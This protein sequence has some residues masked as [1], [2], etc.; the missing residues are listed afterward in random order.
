MYKPKRISLICPHC[1]QTFE[2][3]KKKYTAEIKQGKLPRDFF[4]SLK[5]KNFYKGITKDLECK[6]CGK[7]HTRSKSKIESENTFCSQSCSATFNNKNKKFGTRRSKLE[8]YLEEKLR[9]LYPNLEIQYN[10]KDTINSELDFYIPS[11]KLAFEL[12]GIFHY[13]PIYGQDKLEKIKNND[14][15]KFQA[16]L[17][18]GIELCII[19]SSSMKYFKESFAVKYLDIFI[20]IINRKIQKNNN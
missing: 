3:E 6:N 4:C 1:N 14:S 5:C 7:V 11:L 8:V 10:K 20:N 18:S 17:E 13:E 19:N 9:L 15:R 12:N 2:K 16:C